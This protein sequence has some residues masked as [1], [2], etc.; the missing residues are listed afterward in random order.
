MKLIKNQKFSIVARGKEL[1]SKC[2]ERPRRKSHA[3][4]SECFNKWRADRTLK[5]KVLY[6]IVNTENGVVVY[7]G[8][9]DKPTQRHEMHYT[10]TT[11]TGFARMVHSTGADVKKFKMYVLDVSELSLTDEEHIALEHLNNYKHKDTVVNTDIVIT[12]K[13]MDIILDLEQRGILDKMDTLEWIEYDEFVHKKN[14]SSVCESSD[15][16]GLEK[17][18]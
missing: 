17:N 7:S 3:W 12:D 1:C 15:N 9:S 14:K 11:G 8:M 4:C 13:D 6:Y 18:L 2:K 10:T 5:C 16:L